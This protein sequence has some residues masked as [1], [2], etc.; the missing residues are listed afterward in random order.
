MFMLFLLLLLMVQGCQSPLV[1][2]AYWPVVSQQQSDADLLARLRA[3]WLLLGQK[4]ASSQQRQ[5]AMQRYNAALLVL[6]QRLRYD[7]SVSRSLKRYEGLQVQHHLSR[8]GM[9]LIMLY[10]DIVPAADVSL[11][12]LQ[13]RY[14]MA[15]V[16]VSLVG[17][18]P[19]EKVELSGDMFN[20]ATRGTVSALTAVL[21]FTPRGQPVLNL[22]PRLQQGEVQVGCHQ[23]PLAVDWSALLE[24]YW[25]LTRV[26]EDRILGLFRPQALRDTTGLSSITPY[27]PDKIPVIL[28]HGLLSSAGT[29]DNLVNRLI[30]DPLIRSNYQFWYFNYPTGVAWTISARAYRE[31]LALLRK[32]VDPGRTNRNWE[33]MVLVGHSM[34]GLITHYCQCEA[35]WNLLRAADIPPEHLAPFLKPEYINKPFPDE[36]LN[37]LRGDYFFHPVEA[38]LVVYMATPHRGAPV[39]RYRLA[40]LLSRLVSLPQ[41]LVQEVYNIATLQDDMLLF[42]PSSA[43]QW[44]TSIGQLKPDSYSIVGLQGLSVRDVPTHSIIGDQGDGDCPRCTDGVVPYWS[45]HISWGTETIVPSDHSVQDAPETALDMKRLLG[46]YALRYPA[47]RLRAGRKPRVLQQ[48]KE[49]RNRPCSALM[50]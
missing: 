6:V 8:A 38:G 24:V 9:N 36:Q 3:D 35:P 11:S 2:Q 1:R 10:D 46:D 5:A 7:Y 20:I 15:G 12:D 29:F 31:S 44:F 4:G 30:S 21:S 50:K 37:A 17:I 41:T 28:T 34:G 23:Y 47:V 43:W 27:D 48:Y 13:E 40:A 45:S 19:P 18:I 14:T 16:G 26:K 39:A 25:S 42:N 49:L 22:I 33:R 32:R